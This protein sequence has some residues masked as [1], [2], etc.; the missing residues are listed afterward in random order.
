MISFSLSFPDAGGVFTRNINKALQ[1]AHNVRAGTMWVNTYNMT[2]ASVP[3]GGVC[4]ATLPCSALT[5]LR[6]GFKQS[7]FGRDLSQHALEAYTEVKAVII[8]RDDSE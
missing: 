1:L 6:A 5:I 8:A 4:F 3:F 7:G 2:D